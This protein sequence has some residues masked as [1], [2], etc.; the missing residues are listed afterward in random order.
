MVTVIGS[1]TTICGL[2]SGFVAMSDTALAVR[3]D[4]VWRMM[5]SAIA[6]PSNGVP[7]W[8]VMPERALIVQTV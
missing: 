7:S 6:A 3:N 8:N 5:L 1:V 2:P 4:F